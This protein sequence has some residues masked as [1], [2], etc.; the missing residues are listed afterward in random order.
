[1]RVPLS[2]NKERASAVAIQAHR[3]EV[4]CQV[5]EVNF[6]PAFPWGGR[7]RSLESI[8]E[9][10]KQQDIAHHNVGIA[11]RRGIAR[12]FFGSKHEPRRM[13]VGA[14]AVQSDAGPLVLRIS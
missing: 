12:R 1:M 4:N 11:V 6:L 7:R 3:A 14:V 13:E 5:I 8:A 10:E 2:Q 9:L